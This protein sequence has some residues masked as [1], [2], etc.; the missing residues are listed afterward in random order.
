[1]YAHGT[2]RKG[3]T[4]PTE[5]MQPGG[6]K[7]VPWRCPSAHAA[8]NLLQDRPGPARPGP[9]PEPN[10]EAREKILIPGVRSPDRANLSVAAGRLGT[11][12]GWQ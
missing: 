9:A 5:P 1:M 6:A 3:P 4:G 7:A 12:E 8:C 2:G 10:I 11:P